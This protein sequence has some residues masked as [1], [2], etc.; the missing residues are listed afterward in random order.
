MSHLHTAPVSSH[1]RAFTLIELLVV[2]AVIALLA[3][4]LFPVFAK[5]RENARRASCQSNLKQIGL[6][7]LQYIQDYDEVLPSAAYGTTDKN[8]ES[9]T[10]WQDVIYPYVKSEQIFNCPSHTSTSGY[11][12]FKAQT[13]PSGALINA[14]NNGS[15]AINAFYYGSGAGP[16]SYLDA[17]ASPAAGLTPRKVT[18]VSVPAETVW[19]FDV[20]GNVFFNPGINTSTD[21]PV[22]NSSLSYP[23]LSRNGADGVIARHLE[24]TNVLWCDGHVKSVKVD[25]LATKSGTLLKY[26]TAAAD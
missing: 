25:L 14:N 2:I 3:A 24:T 19:S 10:R 1:K 13:A 8:N 26:F 9:Y 23:Y 5:A 21:S 22:L 11:R 12:A 18:I 4:I 20:Y 7:L 6:G 15:Y 16:V 17:D